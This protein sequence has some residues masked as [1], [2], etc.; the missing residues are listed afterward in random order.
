MRCFCGLLLF[1][2][3]WGTGTEVVW[4]DHAQCARGH[5]V[6][7]EVSDGKTIRS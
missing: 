5:V 7:L 2:D 3:G 4:A 6:K 1:R